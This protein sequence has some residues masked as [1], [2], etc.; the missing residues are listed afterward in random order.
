MFITVLW[1]LEGCPEPES[2]SSFDDVSDGAWY[3][4]AAAWGAETGLAAGV[5]SNMFAPDR[6]VT[7]EQMCVLVSK[8]INYCGYPIKSGSRTGF[9]DAGNIS[10]WALGN[11]DFC[12]GAGII[13]GYPDGS[14][15][16]QGDTTRAA[17]CAV[18]YNLI[19]TI[20]DAYK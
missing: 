2:S 13:S 5:G 16:P 9:T 7:R 3:S 10:S 12:S 11:V 14:F 4:K 8:Y 1:N 20:L 17:C 19:N 6:S 15:K 18:F